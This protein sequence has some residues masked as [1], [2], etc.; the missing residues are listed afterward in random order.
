MISPREIGNDFSEG[1]RIP[2][3]VKSVERIDRISLSKD[4][5]ITFSELGWNLYISHDY[6][7]VGRKT[8]GG[9]VYISPPKSYITATIVL[10]HTSHSYIGRKDF[11]SSNDKK[12]NI[13]TSVKKFIKKTLNTNIEYN[14]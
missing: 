4:L 11:K 2:L 12:N 6:L 14:F 10:S 3:T 7:T 1:K 9:K 13:I 5:L 8:M